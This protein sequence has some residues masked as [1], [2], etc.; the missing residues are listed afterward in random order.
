MTRSSRCYHHVQCTRVY[1]YSMCT[2]H[3]NTHI[4][5][6]TSIIA[7]CVIA[8]FSVCMYASCSS[9][10]EHGINARTYGHTLRHMLGHLTLHVCSD[11]L[12]VRI[13]TLDIYMHT[14]ILLQAFTT[15]FDR[16]ITREPE[17]DA[18]KSLDIYMFLCQS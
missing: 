15:S 13:H 8:K 2:M 10:R 3:V 17:R 14:C 5:G 7:T 18:K 4:H 12:Y 6:A 1:T 9:T 16:I 11:V